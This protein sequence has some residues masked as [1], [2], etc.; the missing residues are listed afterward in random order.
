MTN[1]PSS[2]LSENGRRISLKCTY[3]NTLIIIECL[4]LESIIEGYAQ[5]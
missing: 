4:N 1:Q 2:H 5:R 3:L